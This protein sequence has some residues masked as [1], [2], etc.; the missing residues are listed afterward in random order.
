MPLLSKTDLVVSGALHETH[1]NV[2][3]EAKHCTYELVQHLNGS[4]PVEPGVETIYLNRDQAVLIAKTI[5]RNEGY[6]I[7]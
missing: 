7:E 6:N 5:L 3:P 1:L 2:M 4:E